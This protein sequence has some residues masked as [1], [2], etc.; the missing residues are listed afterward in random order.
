MRI[1]Y[2]E[3]SRFNSNINDNFDNIMVLAILI[4]NR[5]K[6]LSAYEIRAEI[7]E[8]VRNF[9]ISGYSI[10]SIQ[11]L[12]SVISFLVKSHMVTVVHITPKLEKD[13]V[14]KRITNF[15]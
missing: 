8:W 11:E 5:K 7:I 6:Y 12:E 3:L 4:K 1:G 10:P 9:E 13:I 2:K 14:T 15:W